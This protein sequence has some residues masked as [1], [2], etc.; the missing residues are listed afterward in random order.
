MACPTPCN[1][2]GLSID[3]L[4]K[5]A[6]INSGVLNESKFLNFME[7][8]EEVK[9]EYYDNGNK[10]SEESFK[11]GVRNGVSTHWY[12]DGIKKSE[13]HY[14]DGELHGVSTQWYA[15][16]QKESE[17]HHQYGDPMGVWKEWHEDGSRKYEESY[18]NG[19]LHGIATGWYDKSRGAKKN[20]EDRY[21]DGNLIRTVYF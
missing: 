15:N 4:E 10:M 7:T 20:Y 3:L 13:I 9:I 1:K 6:L 17:Y 12:E 16:G 2:I 5:M 18:R 19:K 11:C 8:Q 14:K 21:K